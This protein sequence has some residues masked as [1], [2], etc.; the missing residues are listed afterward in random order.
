MH[1]TVDMRA[2][3]HSRVD[4]LRDDA[5]SLQ[6]LGVVHLVPRVPHPAW[7]MDTHHVGQIDYLHRMPLLF[8]GH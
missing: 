6:I 8:S 4:S 2:H 3:V 5:A 1:G 7:R